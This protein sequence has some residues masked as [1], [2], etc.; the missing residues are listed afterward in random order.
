MDSSRKCAKTNIQD[1][2]FFEKWT[3]DNNAKRR[4]FSEKM[5]GYCSSGIICVVVQ[6]LDETLLYLSY[7]WRHL[8]QTWTS[9][10]L[11][12]GIATHLTL[13][14]T[15]L[16]LNDPG[17][18]VGKGENAGY[19]KLLVTSIFSFSR[20]VLYPSQSKF[21]SHIFFGHLQLLWNWIRIKNF[22]FGAEITKGGN[23]QSYWQLCPF[24]DYHWVKK[25]S[26]LTLSQTSPGFYVSQYKSFK[27]TA[28]KREIARN[29]QFLLFPQCF[30]PI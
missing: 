11:I 15:I 22:F 19:K 5:S 16:T 17:K 3:V 27:N 26:A 18:E 13:Y 14:H 23:Y 4:K 7:E 9:C 29:K 24:F 2:F 1:N 10:W 30:L 28:G 8:L 21:L 20:S 12:N 25:P 6:K